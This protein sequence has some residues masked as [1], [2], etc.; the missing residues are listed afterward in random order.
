LAT[1]IIRRIR[2]GSTHDFRMP[3]PGFELEQEIP[4][5][6]IVP[7]G[8]HILPEPLRHEMSKGALAPLQDMDAEI[9][10]HGL[11]IRNRGGIQEAAIGF[12]F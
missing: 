11:A 1:R 2:P 3:D 9:S 7:D 4:V 8:L 5:F 6:R 12:R 10:I